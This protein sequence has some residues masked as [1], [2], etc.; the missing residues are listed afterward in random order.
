MNA[1]LVSIV[2]VFALLFLLERLMPY[3][4]TAGGREEFVRESGNIML[5]LIN[6]VLSAVFTYAIT[7][8]VLAWAGD[9]HRGLHAAVLPVPLKALVAFLIL[10]CWTYGWHRINH[11]QPFFWR[12]HRVHHSDTLLSA[13]THFRFHSGEI[14][15][16]MIIR[17]PLLAVLGLPMI[18]LLAYDLALNVCS[19]FQH[20]NVRL[21]EPADR[22]LRMIFV[23]PMM[24]RVHHSTEWRETNSNYSTVFSFW[25]RLF[26]SYRF[27]RYADAPRIGMNILR[28]ARWNR[29][30]NLL[31]MPFAGKDV[32]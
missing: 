26:R 12:F 4:R 6:A 9:F 10:D 17:L 31:R 30:Y 21:A 28:S 3:Y 20:G 27:R 18:H 32:Q 7:M 8:P 19:L 16:S 15:L 14:L 22:A 5:A 11:S 1:K 24:H 2:G 23:T 25:D 13:S 29:I